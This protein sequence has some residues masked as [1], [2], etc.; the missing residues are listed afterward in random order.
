MVALPPIEGRIVM[1][2]GGIE[3]VLHDEVFGNA[4]GAKLGNDRWN[5]SIIASVVVPKE[6]YCVCDAEVVV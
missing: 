5:V 3:V 4:M 2:G 6:S 1:S